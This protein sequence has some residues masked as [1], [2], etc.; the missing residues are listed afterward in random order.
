MRR[1]LAASA[2]V[3]AAAGMLAACG[4]STPKALTPVQKCTAAFQA[5]VN[6]GLQGKSARDIRAYGTPRDIAIMNA[7]HKACNA[8]TPAQAR[9]AAQAVTP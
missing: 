3:L 4:G 8:L 2:A 6:D 9:K 1:W 7:A 5:Y